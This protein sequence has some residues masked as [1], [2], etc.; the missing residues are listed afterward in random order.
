MVHGV[1]KSQTRLTTLACC[2][3]TAEKA[4][5]RNH[6]CQWDMRFNAELRFSQ[7]SYSVFHSNLKTSLYF[8]FVQI[9]DK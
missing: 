4:V 7:K 5:N 2:V 3:K 6:C 9:I 1:A 8:L